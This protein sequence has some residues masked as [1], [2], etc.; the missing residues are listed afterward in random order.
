MNHT[1]YFVL[2]DLTNDYGGF[3]LN[4]SCLVSIVYCLLSST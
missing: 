3:T 2:Y 1:S 4:T